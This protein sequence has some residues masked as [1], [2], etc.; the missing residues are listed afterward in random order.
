MNWNELTIRAIKDQLDSEE[1]GPELLKT[2]LEDERVGVVKLARRKLR[3]LE[4]E[5]EKLRKWEELS[6]LEKGLHEKGYQLVAGIDEAGRGPLAGP[7]VAAAVVF[8][9]GERIIGLDDSKKLSEG[10]RDRLFEIISRKALALGTGIVDNQNID[11]INIM[12]ATLMAMKE[13]VSKLNPAPDYI[14]VDGNREIP[15]LN[16]EQQTVIDGDARSNVIAAASI[17]AKVSRDRL[18]QEYHKKYPAYGFDSHKGYGTA[19]HIR[20]L[21]QYGPCPIHRY[22]FSIVNEASFDK[23]KRK[24]RKAES[25]EQLHKIGRLIAERGL[26]TEGNLKVLRELYRNKVKEIGNY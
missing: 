3:E 2:L 17:I 19:G 15:G 24:I 4:R 25:E 1:V 9:P 21:K 8:K 23:F 7:V 11:R 12:Q 22:S 16:L 18:L 5:Q 26:F 20:A 10:E 6:T 13:A 14:L